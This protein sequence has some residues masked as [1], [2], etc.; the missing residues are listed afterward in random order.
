MRRA[1]S[2]FLEKGTVNT[3][4]LDEQVIYKRVRRNPPAP[5]GPNPLS[6]PP[7]PQCLV[8]VWE[9]QGEGTKSNQWNQPTTHRYPGYT[10]RT[11]SG[12]YNTCMYKYCNRYF[13]ILQGSLMA[14]ERNRGGREQCLGSRGRAE[15]SPPVGSLSL[16]DGPLPLIPPGCSWR[17]VLSGQCGSGQEDMVSE[18]DRQAHGDHGV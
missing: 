8:T 18:G 15:A 5:C 3:S 6:A 9:G 10:V 17:Q 2:Q 16:S 13:I 12:V 1:S 11:Q 7:I 4:G 14:S